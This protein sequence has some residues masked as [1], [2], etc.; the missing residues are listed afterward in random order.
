MS[1]ASHV[2]TGIYYTQIINSLY[3]NNSK[4][5]KDSPLLLRLSIKTAVLVLYFF[6]V[7]LQGGRKGNRM[8][9]TVFVDGQHGTTG[10]KIRERL[11]GRKDI[12]V[13]EIPEEKR[14][15]PETR[16]KLLNEADIVFLCLPDDAQR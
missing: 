14:K 9:K 12:E 16:Q 13:I 7:N 3:Q 8:K 5:Q 15:D 11:N 2:Q 10:L 1:S 4:R 6:M